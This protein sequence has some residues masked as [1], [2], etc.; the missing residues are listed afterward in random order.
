MQPPRKVPATT[1]RVASRLSTLLPFAAPIAGAHIRE[2]GFAKDAVADGERRRRP[3]RREAAA[4][5]PVL[6]QYMRISACL[7][8]AFHNAL[9]PLSN[10]LSAISALWARR[11]PVMPATPP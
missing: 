2:P 3:L 1:G 8:L 7:A 10:P 5:N 11:F 9:A 4:L 6:F